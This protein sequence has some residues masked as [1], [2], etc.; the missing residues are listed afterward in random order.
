MA[1]ESSSKLDELLDALAEEIGESRDKGRNVALKMIDRGDG[2]ASVTDTFKKKYLGKRTAEA[3]GKATE[4]EA[5]NKRL[6]DLVAEKDQEIKELQSKEP[7]WERRLKDL[8]AKYQKK[9]EEA[10]SKVLD[11]RKAS[12]D[13]RVKAEQQKFQQALRIGLPGGVDEDYGVLLPA[14]YNSHFV[15]DP[16]SRTVKVLELGETESYYDPAEGDPAEQL[17]RDVLARIPP[18]VRIVGEPEAG[19]GVGSQSAIGKQ[20]AAVMAAKRQDPLYGGF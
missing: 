14:Q 5:E 19:G 7:N 16:E 6:T 8:E 3:A 9:I 13:D 10:E 18:K 12:L 4:L 11:E 20:A 1:N 2:L 17:A 15:K